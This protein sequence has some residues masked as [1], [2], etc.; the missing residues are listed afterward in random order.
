MHLLMDSDCL[1]KLAKSS[2]K[3]SVCTSFTVVIPALVKKEVAEAT[4][5]HPEVA[6]IN[7]NLRRKILTVTSS[8]GSESKGEEAVFTI[9]ESGRFDAICSDDK[10]FI[11]RLRLFNV[12]YLTPAVLIA[13]LLTQKKITKKEALQKLN[14]LSAFISEQEHF[15]VRT[16]LAAWKES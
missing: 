6:L 14:S 1:I 10:R 11:R 16:F 15:T 3:E 8:G 13:L 4:P 2:V 9:F 12:P 7:E 5:E